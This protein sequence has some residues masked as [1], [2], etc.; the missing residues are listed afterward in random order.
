MNRSNP[1]NATSRLGQLLGLTVAAKASDLHLS[2][3]Q[4]PWVR[5]N[6][7]LQALSDQP[8]VSGQDL[9]DCLNE[10]FKEGDHEQYTTHGSVD[11]ATSDENEVRFRFNVSRVQNQPSLVLR[12]LDNTFR[13][14]A[15]LGLSQD[16]L[17][18][19]DSK[20][21]L[22]LVAG[23][24][25]SGKSTTLASLIHHINTQQHSHIVTIEDPVEFIHH[26]IK[27]RISQRQ[28]G[29][30]T[31]HFS[32]AIRDALRQDPDV[33]LVG[34]LRDL[35][36]ITAA[37][38]ASQTGHLVFG[39]VHA[40]DTIGTID[41]LIGVFPGEEQ[42]MIRTLLS[43]SLR[44]VIAQHLLPAKVDPQQSTQTH[45]RILA[46]EVLQLNDAARNLIRKGDLNGLRSILETGRTDG[47]YTLDQSLAKLLR[48]GRICESVAKSL[49]RNPNML[50][51]LARAV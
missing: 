50:R 16:L 17:K 23:P 40:S 46:S 37:V 15:D 19:C 44:T 21:G 45:P 20:D 12:R 48:A 24:T 34:E 36:T 13:S 47:M 28:V 35:K 22:V 33:I 41:R 51:E 1:V 2:A 39:T 29:P 31:G 7:Q 38:E 6:G 43:S 10:L 14:L 3:D 5:V 4:H 49:A 18:V 30:D 42:S 8:V 9:N 27:A 11:G 26:S 32:H 25:G